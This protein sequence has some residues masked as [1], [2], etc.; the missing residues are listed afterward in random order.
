[1]VEVSVLAVRDFAAV[2]KMVV[3]VVSYRELELK[4]LIIYI[5]SICL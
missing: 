4:F 5:D 3:P 2:R 1:M